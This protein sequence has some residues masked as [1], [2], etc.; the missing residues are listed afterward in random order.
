MDKYV[1]EKLIS[2]YGSPLYVFNSEAFVNNYIELQS[3]FRKIYPKYTIAYSYKTNYTPRICQIVK[4][5]GGYAEVVSDMEYTLAKKIGYSNDKIIYN[6]P[7][8]GEKM[9]EH[10]LLGGILNID[11]LQESDRVC[12]IAKANKTKQF[13]VGIRVNIDVEQNF[14]S[15]FG[16]EAE[17]PEYKEAFKKLNAISNIKIVGL[18]CHISRA[19]G[20]EAWRKRAETMLSLADKYIDGPP[21]YINLGSGMFAHMEESLANQFGTDI[22]TYNHYAEAVATLFKDHYSEI[23][24]NEKPILF[25]E[26]G[27]T[28]VSR[29]MD[30]ISKVSSIKNIRGQD[31][32]ILNG[33]KDNIGDICTIKELPINVYGENEAHFYNIN[34]TGYTCLEQDV[35]YEGYI[36]KIAV[37]NYVVFKNVGG[38]S[39]VTK[40]PFI[41]P[42][43]PMIEIDAK[44]NTRLIKRMETFEDVFVTYQF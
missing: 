4:G 41:A 20:I 22:P 38:Y 33:S 5:L 1:V 31:I 2:E 39:N 37:G 35:M 40:P 6:G 25:T 7:N 42:N 15:R 17:G 16:L 29:Y 34:L 13:N 9:V 30:F 21:Q 28:L 11:N 43:C 24:E 3:A 19:R 23:S 36:G 12:N 10:L 18:H 32:A 14:I 44:G 26:P 27:T 8:K